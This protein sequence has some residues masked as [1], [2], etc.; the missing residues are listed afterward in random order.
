MKK[1]IWHT[2]VGEDSLEVMAAEVGELENDE[3]S[4]G[5]AGFMQGYED[6]EEYE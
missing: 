5:E 2:G 6:A 4:A 1:I 3:L